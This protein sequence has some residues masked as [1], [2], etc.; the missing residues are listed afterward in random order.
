MQIAG[1]RG[2]SLSEDDSVSGNTVK[3]TDDGG[4]N[5]IGLLDHA[6]DQREHDRGQRRL[7]RRRSAR[8]WQTPTSRTARSWA[9]AAATRRFNGDSGGIQSDK[10][11]HLV[12]DTIAENECFNGVGL[13]RGSRGRRDLRERHR[14]EQPRGIGEHGRSEEVILSNCSGTIATT[15]V[16]LDNGGECDFA[17]HGGISNTEPAAR[18]AP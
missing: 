13:R 2:T 9:T 12:N 17:A 1:D 3:G 14:G 11:L 16:N 18:P 4:G 10:S 15:G 6:H 7:Q 5:R 8:G